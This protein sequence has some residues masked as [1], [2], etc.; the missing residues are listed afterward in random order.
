MWLQV[1]EEASI[2]QFWVPVTKKF[3]LLVEEIN[4]QLISYHLW[5]LSN[6]CLKIEVWKRGI[7]FFLEEIYICWGEN[8]SYTMVY[9]AE[10]TE[11]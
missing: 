5:I 1:Y 11:N 9:T 7:P 10:N 6:A 8:N 4:F 2:V 3:K